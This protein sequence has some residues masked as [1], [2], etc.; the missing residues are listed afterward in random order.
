[1]HIYIIDKYDAS[2]PENVPHFIS[3]RVLGTSQ[4]TGQRRRYLEVKMG[5][6]GSVAIRINMGPFLRLGASASRGNMPPPVGSH[7]AIGPGL[8]AIVGAALSF[9]ISPN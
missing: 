9:L 7:L 5:L 3:L 6:R 8:A 4:R 2:L 1:M